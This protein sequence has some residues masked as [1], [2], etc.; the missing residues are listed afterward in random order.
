MRWRSL[1]AGPMAVVMAEVWKLEIWMG[2]HRKPLLHCSAPQSWAA[3][4]VVAAAAL[5]RLLP[6]GR[7]L[8]NSTPAWTSRPVARPL[9]CPHFV[10]AVADSVVDRLR[11]PPARNRPPPPRTRLWV[12][13][14]PDFESRRRRCPRWRRVG[15]GGH[16]ERCSPS[17]W[18]AAS[19]DGK[20]RL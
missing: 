15:V 14:R 2:M 12:R 20:K 17:P 11:P 10:A 19:V 6:A 18:P 16:A 3:A 13:H 5:C 8:R 7:V 1:L 4:A 9:A